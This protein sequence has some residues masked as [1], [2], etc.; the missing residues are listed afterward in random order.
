MKR[1]ILLLLILIVTITANAQKDN[2]P[3]LKEIYF[4]N[5]AGEEIPGKVKVSDKWVYMVIESTNAIGEK[6]VLKMDEDGEYFYKKE[7]PS[8]LL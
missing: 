8:K 1:N 3:L 2:E 6:V 5:R 7:V 4:T